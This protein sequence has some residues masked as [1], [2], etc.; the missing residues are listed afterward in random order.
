MA[1]SAMQR[2]LWF[3]NVQAAARRRA[4]WRLRIRLVG[5][6]LCRALPEWLL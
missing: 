1:E 2:K 3:V 6:H 4:I 5:L